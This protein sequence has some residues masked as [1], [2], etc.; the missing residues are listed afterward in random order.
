MTG[1][2]S[3]LIA[4]TGVRPAPHHNVSTAVVELLHALGVRSVFGI[5]GGAIAP[6]ADVLGRAASPSSPPVLATGDAP[7]SGAPRAPGVEAI[8]FFAMRHEGGAAFAATEA[9]I[10]GRR[11][12]CVMTT[13]G[14]GLTNALTGIV[15]AR[16]EGA[17]VLVISA[18]T[19]PKQRGR[20][21]VQEMSDKAL[22]PACAMPAAFDF[23]ATIE[24]AEDLA[25]AADTIARGMERPQ[26]FVAH[27]ALSLAVQR[28]PFEGPL[29]PRLKLARDALLDERVLADVERALAEPFAIW[30]GFGARHATKELRAFAEKMGA[31][32]MLTPRG[33]GVFPEDHPLFL[34]VTGIGGHDVDARLR[35][36]NV[37]RTLVVGSRLGEFTSTWNPALAPPGGFVHVDV[38][39]RV[40][41]AAY[42]DVPTL[43]VV[44]DARAFLEQMTERMPAPTTARRV[45]APTSRWST[46]SAP[47]SSPVRPQVLMQVVQRLVVDQL[48]GMS[49]PEHERALVFAEPGNSFAWANHLLRF[50]MPDYRLSGYWASMGHMVTGAVG[51]A[52]ETKRPCVVI[53]GDGSMLM[54]SELSTAVQY[55]APV[56]WI[57]LNDGRYG[58]TEDGMTAQG[59]APVHTRFPRVDFVQLARSVGADGL[60]VK[61]EA[62]LLDAIAIAMDAKG[63]FVVD[64]D[65]DTTERAPFLARVKQLAAMGAPS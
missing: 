29:L 42:P 15:A 43:G 6:F 33:K 8:R 28:A 17:H 19:T 34:G 57:V 27:I 40:F 55:R 16:S 18:C 61:D 56:V 64:V 13:T 10:A 36:L 52:L 31:P 14:P 3:R 22:V 23:S 50:A 62:V 5:V 49:A 53:T 26:G 25:I 4:R 51:A 44:A 35:P 9:S 1:T 58:M 21:A 41:S 39:A 46:F 20:Y 65:I 38:D 47:T 60:T 37:H 32:V 12:T 7:G 24:R 54:Q 59:F 30:A 2:V 45:H 63:P 11:P 48:G